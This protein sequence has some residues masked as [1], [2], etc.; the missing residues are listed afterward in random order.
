VAGTGELSDGKVVAFDTDTQSVA[1]SYD[2]GG[3]GI[4][5]SCDSS[6]AI[7]MDGDVYIGCDDG[8]L[9]ALHGND[10]SLKT[11]FPVPLHDPDL[12]TS[13]V[14]GGSSPAVVPAAAGG[15]LVFMT[16]RADED[17]V[18]IITGEGETLLAGTLST[19]HSSITLSA[20]GTWLLHTGPFL[21]AYSGGGRIE[22]Y[23]GLGDTDATWLVSSPAI[24]SGG[25]V[26]VLENQGDYA[27]DG[28]LY[29]IQ[30]AAELYSNVGSFPKFRGDMGNSGQG[31]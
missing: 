29:A 21:A 2:G 19:A 18:F 24:G 25:V 4:T 30:G 27:P 5:G 8:M 9:Y 11:G 20:N 1:W 31:Y 26:Y 28:Y 15:E 22:W 14:V 23:T 12:A 6:P 13:T 3:S 7:G 17:N 10:G 16:S